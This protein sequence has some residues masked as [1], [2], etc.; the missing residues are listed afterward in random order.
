MKINLREKKN[1]LPRFAELLFTFEGQEIV[2]YD[3]QKKFLLDASPFRIIMKARQL[4]LSWVIALEG[5]LTALLKP[6]QTILFVS[7]GEEAAKRVLVY[8]YAFING[9][10]IKPKLLNSSMTEC[11]FANQSRIV[12]LPNNSRCY[13][14]DT[15]I[16]TKYGWK[17]FDKLLDDDIVGQVDSK[18]LELTYVKPTEVVREHFV[19][20]MYHLKNRCFD[21]LITP[22]HRLLLTQYAEIGDR[23][24]NRRVENISELT[25]SDNRMFKAVKFTGKEIDKV[26]IPRGQRVRHCRCKGVVKTKNFSQKIVFSGDDFC[27]FMGI[28]LAEGCSF[29]K[30]GSFYQANIAQFPGWKKDKIEKFLKTTNI[31]FSIYKTG[32]SFYNKDL[33]LYLKQF[34]YV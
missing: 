19:G 9:M 2:L 4:G 29:F 21:L 11:R 22:N 28:Y 20:K 25:H 12:S 23:L 27:R 18:T 17:R 31:K 13:S 3:Y 16:L 10:S 26:E 5:L 1:W 14:G 33:C 6:Y 34:V 32:F 30:K 7:S 15:E 8:V 24:Y